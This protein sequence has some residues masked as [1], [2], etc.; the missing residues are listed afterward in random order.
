MNPGR[1][2]LLPAPA[3]ALRRAVLAGALAAALAVLGGCGPGVGGTG[4][5]GLTFYGATASTLCTSELAA[6]LVCAR[7]DG[8][9]AAIGAPATVEEGTAA[10]HFADHESRAGV[11][12]LLQANTVELTVPCRRLR[13]SGDWGIAAEG[14]TRF[15]GSYGESALAGEVPAT[16]QVQAVTAGDGTAR[17]AVTLRDADGRVVLG[18]VLLQRVAQPAAAAPC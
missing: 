6:T 3:T 18:P 12:A 16:L 8:N 11:L 4:T 10:V 15:F 1:R 5:G 17:L 7:S 9:P 14:D 2:L 13:F